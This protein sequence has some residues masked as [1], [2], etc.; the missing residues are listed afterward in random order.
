MSAQYRH[1]LVAVGLGATYTMPKVWI[2]PRVTD[3]ALCMMVSCF[4]ARQK[5]DEIN[6][7]SS[8]FYGDQFGFRNGGSGSI[9]VS[10]SLLDGYDEPE[11]LPSSNPQISPIG[12]DVRQTLLSSNSPKHDQLSFNMAELPRIPGLLGEMLISQ[13]G[14][15]LA[16]WLLTP[17]LLLVWAMLDARSPARQQTSR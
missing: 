5:L 10:S 12:A 17:V 9:P 11:I 7:P 8:E 16:C 15:I 4:L 14:S 3:A 6:C 13:C 2:A 1:R